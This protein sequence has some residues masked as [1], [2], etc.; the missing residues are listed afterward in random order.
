MCAFR[1]CSRSYSPRWRRQSRSTLPFSTRPS[2]QAT[3]STRP[4]PCPP[5]SWRPRRNSRCFR[6][7]V[8]PDAWAGRGSMCTSGPGA[9]LGNA[10][11]PQ[12]RRSQPS[13]GDSGKCSVSRS[14]R[15]CTSSCSCCRSRMARSM[16]SLA[17]LG[18]AHAARR[19]R[20]R[21]DVHAARHKGERRSPGTVF[22]LTVMPASSS[23]RTASRP[24][25][26]RRRI[27]VVSVPSVAST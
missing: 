6:A 13:S 14:T 18:R 16:G 23:A 12:W 17:H 22:L 4:T 25:H 2:V 10:P 3:S 21:P 11:G 5:C 20:R 15:R 9:G 27:Q 24:V 7:F 19:Q 8:V 26:E 1:C